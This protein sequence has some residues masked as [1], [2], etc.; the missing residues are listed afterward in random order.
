ML[1]YQPVCHTGSLAGWGNNN[2]SVST[3]MSYRFFNWMGGTIMLVY[4]PACH[5]GSL[6]GWGEQ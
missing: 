1:V 2:V 5:T 3:S 6:A 4:Q